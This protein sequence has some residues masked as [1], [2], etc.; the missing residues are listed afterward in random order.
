M[1][2]SFSNSWQLVKASWAILMANKQLLWFPALSGLT[3]LIVFII[4]FAPIAVV[5]GV[6][7]M[8]TGANPDSVGGEII[9]FVLLFLMYL[10]SYSVAIFFNTALVGSVLRYMDGEVVSVGSGLRLARSH[11][12]AILGYAVI[13]ATVGVILQ[14]VRERAGLVGQ[15]L[16]GLG[17]MA[18]NLATFL[19]VPVLVAREVGPVEAIKSSARLFRETWGEQV[20]GSF[21]IGA[22]FGLIFFVGMFAGIALVVAMASLESVALVILA[23]LVVVA[24]FV[25]IGI[26]A[27]ALDSIYRAAL[28]R[29]AETG[30]V[31]QEFEIEMITGAFKPKRKR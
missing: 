4:F 13:S 3:M 29:Y 5:T 30:S 1:F 27:S 18:W 14:A 22:V 21:G 25:A 17:G 2:Q 15:I 9:G 8:L 23:V 11:M 16:S 10:V 26:I 6:L 24:F 20:A 28:Y 7:A 12:S 31:P 19:V